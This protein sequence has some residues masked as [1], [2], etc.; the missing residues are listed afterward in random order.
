MVTGFLL[1]ERMTDGMANHLP[2]KNAPLDCRIVH[3]QSHK[4][5]FRAAVPGPRKSAPGARTQFPL[6]SPA[7]PQFRFHETTTDAEDTDWNTERHGGGSRGRR[8]RGVSGQTLMK[9]G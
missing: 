4:L 8:G 3:T 2:A 6:G 7:V 9:H 5:F 1:S